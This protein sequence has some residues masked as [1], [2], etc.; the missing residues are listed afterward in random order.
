MTTNDEKGESS[1]NA[2]ERALD[3]AAFNM[4]SLRTAPVSLTNLPTHDH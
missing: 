4:A 1:I 2:I 3:E